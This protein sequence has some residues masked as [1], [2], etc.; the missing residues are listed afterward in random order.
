M[1][2]LIQD[3]SKLSTFSFGYKPKLNMC[4]W[5]GGAFSKLIIVM[6]EMLG[7]IIFP[8]CPLLNEVWGF[9]QVTRIILQVN[10]AK[11]L[12]QRDPK[13]AIRAHESGGNE[14]CNWLLNTSC[15]SA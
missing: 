8:F 14:A 5:F 3:L 6:V 10:N 1:K 13:I 7:L 12:S 4:F 15:V 9:P 11:Q 2:F